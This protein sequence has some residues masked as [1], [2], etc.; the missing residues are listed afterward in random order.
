M[1]KICFKFQPS[2][3][4]AHEIKRV[5]RERS[6]RMSLLPEIE[7]VCISDLSDMCSDEE[8]F[9]KVGGVSILLP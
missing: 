6:R 1:L 2:R 3:P 4:C 7:T 5:L 9:S 8:E